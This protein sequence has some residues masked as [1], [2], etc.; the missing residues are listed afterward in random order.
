MKTEKNH[1]SGKIWLFPQNKKNKNFE[2][3]AS[4]YVLVK[5]QTNLMKGFWENGFSH[6]HTTLI[7]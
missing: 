7:L 4:I 6:G 2:A 1:S 3:G 5:F